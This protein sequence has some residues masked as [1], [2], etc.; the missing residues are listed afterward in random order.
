[1]TKRYEVIIIGG[2]PAGLTAGMYAARSKLSAVVLERGLP[3]GQLLNTKDIEDYPG[4][5]HVGGFELAELMTK[6]AEKFGCEIATETVTRIAP[7]GDDDPWTR[8]LV[9]TDSGTSYT[10]PM[11]ILAAGGTAIKLGVPGELEYAGRGVSYCAVCDGAFFEGETIAVVGGG[12]AAAEEAD[13]LTRY[14]EKVYLIHRRDSLR[15]QKIIQERVFR[16]PKIEMVWDT[17]VREAEGDAQGLKQLVL[18]GTRTS[19]GDYDFEGTGP[20]RNLSVTGLFVFIGF[21]PNTH[22]LDNAHAKHDAGGHFLTDDRMETSLPGLYA[23][24]DVRSQL[25]RQITTAVG[26]ATTATIAIEKAITALKETHA[27]PAAT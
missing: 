25:V 19:D 8:W 27:E 22:L 6:H 24:G 11:V 14:A 1:M 17:I 4:F 2:G 15:A 18:Q 3:G 12:D 5:P 13:F 23:V 26:D 20:T 10:A 9:E 16:N 7:G 21:E